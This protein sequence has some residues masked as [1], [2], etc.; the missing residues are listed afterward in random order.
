MQIRGRLVAPHHSSIVLQ[1]APLPPDL[2]PGLRQI[3]R[4]PSLAQRIDVHGARAIGNTAHGKHE[5]SL[6][7]RTRHAALVVGL[8]IVMGLIVAP[9]APAAADQ[10]PT[11]PKELETYIRASLREWDI[12]GAAIAVVKDGKPVALFAYGVREI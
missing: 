12:P 8:G 5:C 11:L 9:R 1:G 7:V 2:R 6:M 4:A 3:A 10:Q